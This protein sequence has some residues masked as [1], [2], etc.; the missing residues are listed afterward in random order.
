MGYLD[1]NTLHLAYQ[2][3]VNEAQRYCNMGSYHLLKAELQQ[4]QAD[5]LYALFKSKLDIATEAKR[6]KLLL[7]LSKSH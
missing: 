6:Q 3:R 1:T 4:R 7:L 5:R 2:W